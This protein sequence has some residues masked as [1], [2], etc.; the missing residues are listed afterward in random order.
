M[1]RMSLGKFQPG[2]FNRS[3]A[4]LRPKLKDED[5]EIKPSPPLIMSNGFSD[6]VYKVLT[7]SKLQD[8]D[9][10]KSE[11]HEVY[12]E[13]ELKKFIHI[14]VHPNGGASVVH[15]Y[16][17]EFAHLD[18][19]TKDRLAHLFFEEVFR[20]EP[21]SVAKHVIGIV[22]DSMEYLPEMVSHLSTTKPDLAVKVWVI[23]INSLGAVVVW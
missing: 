12:S 3:E 18:A 2:A 9:K 17:K 8:S 23:Y 13:S 11:N 5:Y 22:H 7:N 10:V 16:E 21:E 4:L 19:G 14:E 15:M 20:E 6:A 1:S